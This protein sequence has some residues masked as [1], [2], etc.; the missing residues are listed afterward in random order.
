[1]SLAADPYQ[2]F[3]VL[4]TTWAVEY[5]NDGSDVVKHT[6]NWLSNSNGTITLASGSEVSGA[7]QRVVF[8]PSAIA[9]PTDAYDVTLTDEHGID[10]LAGQ[11]ANK[12][13]VKTSTV[14]PGTPLKDGTTTTT[15][16]TVVDGILTLNVTNAGNSNA[17]QVVVYVK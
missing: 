17:G 12:S 6:F 2:F 4:E 1:V 7:I 16:P 10:V 14:I 5:R 8:I 11:G 15:V 13:N 9:V 3:T